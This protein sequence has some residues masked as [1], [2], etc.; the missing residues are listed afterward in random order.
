LD[1]QLSFF[2]KGLKHLES[3]EPCVKAVAEKQHID[4]HFSGLDDDSN[5]DDYSSYQDNHSDGSEL[6]FD[7]EIN[8]RDKDLLT[9]RSPMDVSSFPADQFIWH[10]VAKFHLLNSVHPLFLVINH[11]SIISK[12]EQFLDDYLK[13]DQPRRN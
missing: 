6:S 2:R 5:I 4:Y 1:F 13:L 11:S 10:Y 3:L 7:Y 12:Y 8:D 9:S